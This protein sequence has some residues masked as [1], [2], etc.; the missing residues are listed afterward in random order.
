MSM[1]TMSLLKKAQSMR[2]SMIMPGKANRTSSMHEAI[3]AS[4]S[5]ESWT[6]PGRWSRSKICP[7]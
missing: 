6:L 2:T 5:W 4:A 7:V 1:A 3:K